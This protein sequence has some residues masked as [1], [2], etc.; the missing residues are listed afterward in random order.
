[1]RWTGCKNPRQVG[2]CTVIMQNDMSSLQVKS[3]LTAIGV[4]CPWQ[5]LCPHVVYSSTLGSSQPQ[6]IASLNLFPTQS[7]WSLDPRCCCWQ[8]DTSSRLI[9]RPA[10]RIVFLFIFPLP[11]LPLLSCCFFFSIGGC[12]SNRPL[13]LVISLFSA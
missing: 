8:Q 5:Q 10:A 9:L 6:R 11:S 13:L 7:E 3:T 4:G 1:M 12:Y 2:K